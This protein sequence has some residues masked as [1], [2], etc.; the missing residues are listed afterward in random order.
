MIFFCVY[1]HFVRE[2]SAYDHKRSISNKV[3]PENSYFLIEKN[4]FIT[5]SVEKVMTSFLRFPDPKD[6]DHVISRSY[7]P[8]FGAG[9][10][11]KPP[12]SLFPSTSLGARG[13][14]IP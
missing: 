12:P 4:P 7:G 3:L 14:P 6:R 11:D 9:Q 10:A 8:R 1:S 13:S 5:L 2:M